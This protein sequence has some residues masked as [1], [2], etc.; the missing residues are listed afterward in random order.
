MK[1]MLATLLGTGLLTMTA[2]QAVDD[3]IFQGLANLAPM[4]RSI[5]TK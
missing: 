2:A 5:V 4:Q 3:A 1:N